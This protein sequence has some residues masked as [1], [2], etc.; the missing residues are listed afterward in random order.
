MTGQTRAKSKK[1][2]RDVKFCGA[3]FFREG[4]YANDAAAN[5]IVISVAHARFN[6]DLCLANRAK[7]ELSTGYSYSENPFTTMV[8]RLVFSA[9]YVMSILAIAKPLRFQLGGEFL[10]YCNT[11]LLVSATSNTQ[12]RFC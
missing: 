11:A 5:Q 3:S 6:V 8:T 10:G 2:S 4:S 12:G 9:E 1:M 7:K